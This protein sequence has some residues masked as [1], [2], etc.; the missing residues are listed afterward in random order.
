MLDRF[1]GL[2]RQSQ[3]NRIL[4]EYYDIMQKQGKEVADA[5]YDVYESAGR[6]ADGPTTLDQA[7][8]LLNTGKGKGVVGKAAGYLDEAAAPIQQG[9]Q[10]LADKIPLGK[11]GATASRMAGGRVGQV[12]AKG[13]PILGA[14]TAAADV[15]DIVTND[16][17]LGNKAMD[18][19]AMGVGGTIGGI[20][21]LGNPFAIAAGASTGKFLS[22]G[23]QF[24]FGGGKSAEQRKMEEALALLQAGRLG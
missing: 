19:A 20:L 8:D 16:T 15:A 9:L 7:A 22:D 11:G 23:T 24:I 14:V 5:I 21:G 18:T 10:G 1:A 13:L 6:F 2:G 12:I 4:A 3:N 17:S